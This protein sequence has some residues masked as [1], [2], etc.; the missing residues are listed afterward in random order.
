MCWTEC[1]VQILTAFFT[2]QYR[3]LEGLIPNSYSCTKPLTEMSGRNLPGGGGW[4]QP[5]LCLKTLSLQPVNRNCF[6]F[7]LQYIHILPEILDPKLQN[8][9][10][11]LY[12]SQLKYKYIVLW[13]FFFQ[14]TQW[15]LF[16]V[17]YSL[18][19][20]TNL[21]F[22]IHVIHSKLSHSQTFIPEFLCLQNV[23]TS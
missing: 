22:T 19:T 1:A 7:S 14:A 13:T 18:Y 6:G 17:T 9:L 5:P 21:E 23:K 11:I 10:F 12:I 3:S 8:I 4:E 20:C 2:A 16:T 15:L